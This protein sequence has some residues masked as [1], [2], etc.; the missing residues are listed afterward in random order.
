MDETGFRYSCGIVHYVVTRDARKAL[1]LIDPDNRDYITS[2]EC[3]SAAGFEIPPLLILKGENILHKQAAND[4]P[5]DIAFGASP[6][7]YSNDKL[8]LEW[9][10][11]FDK[12]TIYRRLGRWRLLI[13]DGFGS[14]YT[15]E[16]YHLAKT[17]MIDLFVLPAHSTHLTQPLDVG[18][19]QPMKH[20]HSEAV[21]QSVRLGQN[22]FDRLDFLAAFSQ[23][24]SQTFTK[25]TIRSAFRK[26][27]LVP[28][29]PTIV[30]HKIRNTQAATRS[31]TPPPP[32]PVLAQ[33]PHT[34]KNVI[35]FGQTI[36]GAING[37]NI[38]A[39]SFKN[40]IQRYIRGSITGVYSW[41]LV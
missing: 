7:G 35:T 30:L 9:L 13:L 39:P 25:T 17:L 8:A 28:Q 38:V 2:V 37:W 26:T 31:N 11:H 14:Y 1:R 32:I 22:K 18:C 33:T 10:L 19:F 6:T 21:D 15:Y 24:R 3:I 40:Y 20:Y 12:Y 27:S 41:D 34:A 5:D 36:L 23:I 4:L 29:N 16:F